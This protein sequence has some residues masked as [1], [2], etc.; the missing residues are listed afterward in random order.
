MRCRPESGDNGEGFAL[1]ICDNY[2]LMAAN[3]MPFAFSRSKS[4]WSRPVLGVRIPSAVGDVQTTR[5]ETGPAPWLPRTGPY[6]AAETARWYGL[7]RSKKSRCNGG[8]AI[9]E[10]VIRLTY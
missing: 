6:L 10:P 2:W 5:S 9:P 3:L 1:K 7:C 8:I 4:G